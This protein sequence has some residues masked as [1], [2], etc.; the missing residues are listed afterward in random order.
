MF[1]EL[2]DKKFRQIASFINPPPVLAE[3]AY[4][5]CLMI[6]QGVSVDW[7]QFQELAHTYLEIRDYMYNF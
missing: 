4:A 6:F 2:T 5:F 7:Q 1:D 3:V